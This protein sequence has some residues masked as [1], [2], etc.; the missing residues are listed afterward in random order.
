MLASGIAHSTDASATIDATQAALRLALGLPIDPLSEAV[1]Q[2]AFTICARER[3]IP[4]AWRRSQ[5]AIVSGPS[6]KIAGRWRMSALRLSLQTSAQ[7]RTLVDTVRCLQLGGISP[8]VLKGHPLAARLYGD[9]SLRPITDLDLLIEPAERAIAFDTL[10]S[11]GWSWITGEAPFEETFER[12]A[13]AEV[14]R[15]ELHSSL[16]DDPLLEHLRFPVE[17][18]DILTGEAQLPALSGKSLAP[19]L[20][21]HIA[22]HHSVPLLWIVDFHE[23]LKGLTPRQHTEAEETAAAAGILRHYRRAALLASLVPRSAQGDHAALRMLLEEI[24]SISELRRT[25]RLVRLSDGWYDGIRVTAGRVWP[26]QRRNGWRRARVDLALRAATWAYRRLAKAVTAGD[27][28]AAERLASRALVS[29]ATNVT[30]AREPFVARQHDE[31][32]RP[33]IPPSA[34]VQIVPQINCLPSRGEV[35]LVRQDDGQGVLRRVR[36]IGPVMVTVTADALRS[37]S[38]VISRDRILGTATTVS[39]FGATWKVSRSAHSVF[40]LLHALIQKTWPRLR[41]LG[42]VRQAVHVS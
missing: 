1:W 8:V 12:R 33:G 40:P 3:L 39:A 22:K 26:P 4:L 41:R 20:A 15:L 42:R 5:T 19:S 34:L 27:L 28:A 25:L 36:Q 21:I 17:C 32:M 14:H 11:N 31:S 6:Q 18:E 37:R 16:I 7:L 9:A 13:N 30:A 29:S 23:L 10:T 38:W 2:T 35:V 24:G